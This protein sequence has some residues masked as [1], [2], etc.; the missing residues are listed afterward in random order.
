[1]HFG[2]SKKNGMKKICV[3]GHFGYG[4]DFYDGQ[5]IKTKVI[6][7]SLISR[8]S[9]DSIFTIDTHNGIKN[10][11]QLT[12]KLF[13]AMKQC[14]HMIILPAENGLLFIAPILVLFNIFLNK[15][16]HYIVIGGWLPNKV[17]K[18]PILKIFLRKFN[19]IFVETGSMHRK[20]NEMGLKNVNVMA[21]CKNLNILENK[22][23]IYAE[24]IPFKL[25]TFSRVMKEKG[26]EIAIEAVESANKQLN[27]PFFSLDIYGKI[28]SNYTIEFNKLL[29][30]SSDFIQY[31]GVV[32]YQNSVNT[33]KNYYLLLFPT[34]YEGEGFAGTILDSLAAGVPILAS[35]WKYNREIITSD[36]GIIL[37]NCNVESLSNKLINISKNPLMINNLKRNCIDKAHNYTPQIALKKLYN[38]LDS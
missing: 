36:V 25:C 29:N 11:F 34:F 1:M 14:D 15:R 7:Q 9:E 18:I 30:S 31:K 16:I 2:V 13:S 10:I 22:D 8:Y 20:L 5:T 3:C 4:F 24:T 27:C 23:L 6:T 12:F 17:S 21:N 33:I 19:N 32:N 35:N 38:E 26:I 28:D 37:D